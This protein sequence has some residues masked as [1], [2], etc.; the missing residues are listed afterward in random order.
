MKMI[1]NHKSNLATEIARTGMPPLQVDDR[2]VEL[3]IQEY[4]A[5]TRWVTR[6]YPVDRI[7]KAGDDIQ[8]ANADGT[9][10]S[11]FMVMEVKHLL[12]P[13]ATETIR[14]VLLVVE[15]IYRV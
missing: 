6:N 12:V 1:T 5:K 15:R 9:I 7:P 4:S 11:R 2:L 14:A 10:E 3:S 13:Q 8:F